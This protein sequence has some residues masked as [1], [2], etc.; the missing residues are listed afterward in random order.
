MVL[1]LATDAGC[2]R[3]AP[4]QIKNGTSDTL[5]IVVTY[6]ETNY[7]SGEG[8]KPV[9][10]TKPGQTCKPRHFLDVFAT[11]LIEARDAQGTVV[12]SK[13]FSNQELRDMHWEV[14]ITESQ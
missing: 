3:L 10:E 1:V 12:Y 13:L 11:Y 4:F 14:V 5:Y 6:T 7:T 8:L 9:C 2:E